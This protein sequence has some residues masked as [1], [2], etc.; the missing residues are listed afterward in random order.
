MYYDENTVV[1]LDGEW[2]KAKNAKA[3]LYQQSFHY[4]NGVFEGIRSYQTA[5]GPSIWQAE[6][7]YERLLY[8]AKRMHLSLDYDVVTLVD[9][10]QTLLEKNQLGDAY[11]RPLVYTSE[12]MGLGTEDKAHLFICAWDWGQYFEQ[13]GLHL[14]TSDYTRPD[15]ASCHVDAKVTGH[16]ANSILAMKAAQTAGY[17]DALLLD[18]HGHVAEATGANVFI[19]SKGRLLTP[20]K[21]H[22]LP[23][24]TRQVVM[25]MSQ[26]AGIEVVEC[27]LAR[28]DVLKADAMFLT[29]TAVEIKGVASL[30]GHHFPVSWASSLGAKLEQLFHKQVRAA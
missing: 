19:E 27:T 5:Q 9:L 14:V 22:L 28:E 18:K 13:K 15:P 23:G 21:G 1:F 25:D 10:T 29:G 6:A 7:H 17:D 16:Y 24:I 3:G 30:D 12:N 11:I 2:Q 4:G 26:S 20:A 8:S